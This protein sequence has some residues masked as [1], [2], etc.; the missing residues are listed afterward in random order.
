MAAF[1][2]I[3]KN[4]IQGGT[5]IDPTELDLGLF[6]AVVPLSNG[7]TIY[8]SAGEGEL[9]EVFDAEN[10][11]YWIICGGRLI[12]YNSS[13]KDW[14]V[15]SEL[16]TIEEYIELATHLRILLT[17]NAFFLLSDHTQKIPELGAFYDSSDEDDY[18]KEPFDYKTIDLEINK[19]FVPIEEINIKDTGINIQVFDGFLK[20]SDRQEMNFFN[21]E[22]FTWDDTFFEINDE[23]VV[24]AYYKLR[25]IEYDD[26]TPS[27]SKNLFYRYHLNKTIKKSSS[28]AKSYKL[29][30][31][32]LSVVGFILIAA[33]FFSLK[34][35][36][37]S[38]KKS[39]YVHIVSN[40]IPEG[41]ANNYYS[42]NYSEGR[43]TL[44]YNQENSLSIEIIEFEQR[45]PVFFKAI[46]PDLTDPHFKAKNKKSIEKLKKR[47]NS[48]DF[49]LLQIHLEEIN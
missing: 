9:N 39:H 45:N 31:D 3:S 35:I 41:N 10:T 49:E 29:E 1:E 23:K 27:S 13:I 48:V 47:L 15:Y 18:W 43:D 12:F 42:G 5:V 7:E 40:D 2:I 25:D 28:A 33:I 11:C 17:K 4:Q 19:V 6:Y 26:Y 30:S 38:A 34:V 36:D 8:V 24:K 20:I 32:I 16:P 37:Y 14:H 22:S 44:F 21:L 46:S